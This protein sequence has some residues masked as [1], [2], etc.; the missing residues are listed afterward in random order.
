MKNSVKYQDF[1]GITYSS[2]DNSSFMTV[3]A[4]EAELSPFSGYIPL[5]PVKNDLRKS[6]EEEYL[7]IQGR[8]LDKTRS[9][10]VGNA[11]IE[12]WHLTQ[13]SMEYKHRAKLVTDPSGAFQLI[14][15]LPARQR[16]RSFKIYFKITCGDKTFYTQFSFNHC[17]AW[18]SSRSHRRSNEHLNISNWQ[19]GVN[20]HSIF[21][22]EIRLN[23]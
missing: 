6:T 4:R 10:P 16:G 1:T 18:L 3:V 5:S 2:F 22:L 21:E 8:I 23:K 12:V 7:K 19:Q 14:T 15:D 13:G 17:L 11:G 9:W 20:D